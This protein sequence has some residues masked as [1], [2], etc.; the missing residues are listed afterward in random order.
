MTTDTTPWNFDLVPPVFYPLCERVAKRWINSVPQYVMW[1]YIEVV[2]DLEG[3]TYVINSVGEEIG[4]RDLSM[5]SF[6]K[7][8]LL[9][10]YYKVC[11]DYISTGFQ[12][13]EDLEKN[14][15]PNRE[16][17]SKLFPIPIPNLVKKLDAIF[18]KKENE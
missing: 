2:P 9:K 11:I 7:T 8:Y 5:I 13:W 3:T 1:D 10:E 15:S 12:N 14:G 6:V 16:N 17:I 18:E 4:S